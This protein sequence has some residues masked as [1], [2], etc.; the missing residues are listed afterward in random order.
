MTSRT[1]RRTVMK[2]LGGALAGVGGVLSAVA[3]GVRAA[4]GVEN[5]RFRAGD[6]ECTSRDEGA[7]VTC[8]GRT[9]RVSGTIIVPDPCHDGVLRTVEHD[10]ES[11]VL[12][13]V[14]GA[15]PTGGFC[16]QCVA[17]IDYEF[18]AT[19][20]ECLERVVVCHEGGEERRE[21]TTAPCN[22]SAS[23]S[24]PFITGE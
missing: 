11:G 1:N 18:T 3:G 5:T 23:A 13:I 24:R 19:L 22:R 15:E 16:V 21:I 6:A 2:G 14:V 7:T 4:S 10:R 12:R 8:R 17:A 9:V 20:D